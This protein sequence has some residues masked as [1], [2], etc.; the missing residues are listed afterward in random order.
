VATDPNEPGL[1]AGERGEERAAFL[2]A[3]LALSGEFGY[4]EATVERIAVRAGRPV[5]AFF[6]HF[7]TREECFAAAYEQRADALIDRILPVAGGRLICAERIRAAL[8]ELFAFATAE[9]PVAR[10][11]LGEVYVAGG[12]ALAKHEEVLERLSRVVADACRE[13]DPSRHD[14]P[15]MTAS[16]IVGGLEESLR[17]RLSERQAP[18]LWDDLPELTSL[19]I[20]VYRD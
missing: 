8:M 5:E 13:T 15:P 6:R 20:A 9:E 18:R 4:R 3:M 7:P 1:P 19:V 10:A 12:G 11:M 17:R 14:P 16:F 2:A